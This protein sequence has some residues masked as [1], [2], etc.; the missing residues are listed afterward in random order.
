MK[1]GNL[2]LPQHAFALCL[3]FSFSFLWVIGLDGALY[4]IF[5]VNQSQG[6]KTDNGGWILGDRGSWSCSELNCNLWDLYSKRFLKWWDYQWW[7]IVWQISTVPSL[8]MVRYKI[9]SAS[10]CIA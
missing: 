10:C 3:V 8:H 5:L 2:V 9:Y 4:Q 1:V 6:V 7:K